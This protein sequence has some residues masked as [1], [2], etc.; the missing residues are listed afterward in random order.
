MAILATETDL[1]SMVPDV[2]SHGI[3][4]FVSDLKMAQDDIVNLIKSSWWNDAIR[5]NF[6]VNSTNTS[7]QQGF[8]PLDENLLNASALSKII[9][10]R[11]V[12]AYIYPKLS[13]FKTVDGDSFSRKATFYNK[14]YNDE[15]KI[16]RHLPLYDFNK[17]GIFSDLE[18]KIN[19]GRRIQRA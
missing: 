12:S 16:V 19:G 6:I 14:L 17:D 8:I 18:R 1:K 5:N 3:N 9:I 7:F 11:A 2:F 15:W 10:Y 13:T 4:S